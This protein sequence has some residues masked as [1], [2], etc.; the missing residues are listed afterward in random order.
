MMMVA[1][2]IFMMLRSKYFRISI[3][4]Q[5]WV[6]FHPAHYV[7]C[8]Y[9]CFPNGGN[10]YYNHHGCKFDMSLSQKKKKILNYPI[11]DGHFN[12]KTEFL[13]KRKWFIC[14]W[15]PLI[16]QSK[17]NTHQWFKRDWAQNKQMFGFL[18]TQVTQSIYVSFI[19]NVLP[20][21]CVD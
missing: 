7:V 6:L 10:C 20:I 4:A 15:E 8:K 14:Q 9:Q 5:V 18:Q 16:D 3:M 12:C 19:L 2:E 17:T 1:F 13:R 11:N 21:D